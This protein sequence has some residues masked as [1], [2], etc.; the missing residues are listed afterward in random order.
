VPGPRTAR[1]AI[2]SRV[3]DSRLVRPCV[4]PEKDPSTADGTSARLPAA[5]LRGLICMSASFPIRDVGHRSLTSTSAAQ[6]GFSMSQEYRG[7]PLGSVGSL[8][9]C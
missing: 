9:T 4:A 8:T 6:G 2:S 5:L 7:V 3:N 1:T